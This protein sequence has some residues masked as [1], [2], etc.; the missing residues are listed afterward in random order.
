MVGQQV[1]NRKQFYRVEVKN[2]PGYPGKLVF[3]L[4]ALS[5]RKS[6]GMQVWAAALFPSCHRSFFVGLDGPGFGVEK[7]CLAHALGMMRL[8]PVFSSSLFFFWQPAAVSDACW[9]PCCWLW[10]PFLLPSH[11]STPGLM[12]LGTQGPVGLVPT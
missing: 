11:P 12:E 5:C 2:C 4:A 8:L 3:Y 6:C 7:C 9:A 10:S 1:F